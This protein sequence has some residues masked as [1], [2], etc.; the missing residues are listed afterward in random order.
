[1]GVSD[2]WGGGCA[3]RC[4]G[5]RPCEGSVRPA[6]SRLGAGLGLRG[7]VLANGRS[8]CWAGMFDDGGWWRW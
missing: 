2:Q 4:G 6:E 1:L 7:L 8:S 5:N 3:Y